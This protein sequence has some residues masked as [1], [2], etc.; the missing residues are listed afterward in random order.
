MRAFRLYFQ[1][2]C[3]HSEDKCNSTYL[4]EQSLC[5]LSD[6]LSYEFC[7][8]SEENSDSVDLREQFYV[9]SVGLS[10]HTC[11]HSEDKDDSARLCQQS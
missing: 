8:H 2:S 4:R 5:A 9:S 3:T 10:H 7:T 6:Y 11:S 1:L